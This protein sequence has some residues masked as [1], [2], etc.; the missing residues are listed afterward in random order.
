M[1]TVR[2]KHGEQCSA[3]V[4]D[5]KPSVQPTKLTKAV[6]RDNGKDRTKTVIGAVSQRATAQPEVKFATSKSSMTLL[7][8]KGGYRLRMEDTQAVHLVYA[9]REHTEA[10]FA[11]SRDEHSVKCKRRLLH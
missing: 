6:L 2:S 8:G 1:I 4:R 7:T 10:A 11:K 9:V 3:Q 5:L